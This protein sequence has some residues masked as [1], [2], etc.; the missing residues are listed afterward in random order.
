VSKPVAQ[1]TAPAL[2]AVVEAERILRVLEVVAA[3]RIPP[4]L[5]ELAA[6][7]VLGVVLWVAMVGLLQ[8]GVERPATKAYHIGDKT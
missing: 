8:V 5:E 7:E 1:K 6:A 4:A 2:H 3:E